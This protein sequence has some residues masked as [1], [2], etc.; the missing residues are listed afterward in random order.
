[1]FLTLE[2][3]IAAALT[4]IVQAEKILAEDPRLLEEAE[5]KVDGCWAGT[6]PGTSID[7]LIDQRRRLD[8]PHSGTLTRSNYAMM[9]WWLST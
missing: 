7:G 4:K 6:L 5:K 2:V 1:M 8:L 9:T 3:K